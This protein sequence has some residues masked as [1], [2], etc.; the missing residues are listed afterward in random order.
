MKTM[1]ANQTDTV[2]FHI[3]KW[4]TQSNAATEHM[5]HK[6]VVVTDN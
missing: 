6:H 1:S 5:H 2:Q 3:T 4:Q